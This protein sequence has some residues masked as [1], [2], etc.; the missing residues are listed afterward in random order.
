M[1]YWNIFV[2]IGAFVRPSVRLI[3]TLMQTMGFDEE[4]V[5]T[6]LDI[7]AGLIHLGELEF[8][9]NAEDE[10]ASLSEDDEVR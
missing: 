9:A 10:A 3:L 6:I 4:L 7:M 2:T 8:E 1:F 5:S